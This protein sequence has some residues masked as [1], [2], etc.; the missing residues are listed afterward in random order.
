MPR[1]DEPDEPVPRFIMWVPHTHDRMPVIW[2]DAPGAQ[3]RGVSAGRSRPD[4]QRGLAA[5]SG[6]TELR[7]RAAG[8]R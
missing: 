3:F 6:G 4:P 2:D 5:A 1:Q 8:R 7:F